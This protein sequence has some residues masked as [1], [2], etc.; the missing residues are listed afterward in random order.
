MTIQALSEA[1][2]NLPYALSEQV[3]SY[4][5]ALEVAAPEIFRDAGIKQNRELTNVLVFIAGLRK[6]FS[7]VDSNYWVVDNVGAILASQQ[8]QYSVRVGSTDL[9]RGGTY[10]QSLSTIRREFTELL[11]K[12]N[13]IQYVGNV[14]YVDIL[15]E[16][17][18]GH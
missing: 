18:D 10:H 11:T 3:L 17:A 2:D 7:I 6:L 12:H 14:P 16:L 1:I 9:S 4:A 15:R 5:R 13:L 8:E